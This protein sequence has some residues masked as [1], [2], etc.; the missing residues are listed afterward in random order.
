MKFDNLFY[1]YQSQ[2]MTTLAAQGMVATSQ[3]LA[4]QAGLS[5]LHKGGN[6]IDA[7]IAC[8]AA[9]TVLEPT[10]NGIGGDAFALI[11]K[12]GKLHGLNASGYAPHNIS[13]NKIKNEGYNHLPKYGW[14]P[15]TIPGAPA[16][17]VELNK[18]YGNLNLQEI[19]KPAIDYA[20]KGFPISPILGKYWLAAFR[21]YKKV[22]K[23]EK[24]KH[25]FDIFAPEGRPPRISE[26]WNSPSHAKTL[27]LIAETEGK[28]FYR[29]KIADKIVSFSKKTGGYITHNDLF[30]Y[31][32]DWVKPI[33]VNYH[34]YDIWELPPNGQGLVALIALNILDQYKFN[35][36][37]SIDTYHKQIEALKLAFA[38]GK[39]YI[40]DPA[41]MSVK[42]NDLLSKEYAKKRRELIS[43]NAILPKAGRP[44]PGETV[45]L[46]TADNKGNMVSYIQ[47][48]YMGFGS[49]L[50]IPDTGISLQNRGHSFSLN[51]NEENCLEGGKKPYH[52]II[53]G[54]ITKN[55]KAIGPFGVMGG[56]MQPQG[57]LQVVM[58]LIDFKLNPQAALDAPR[59]QWIKNKQIKVEQHFPNYK[60]K[61]LKRK[62]HKIEVALESG[63]FGRGQ[64]IIRNSNGILTGGTEP[65]TDGAIAV[66]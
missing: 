16:A 36:N 58:N 6:A 63:S 8:A 59:W 45:Y 33:S 39:K 24:F 15:V 14:L 46:A 18:K 37:D 43:D 4:A 48:N 5:I 61:A 47:S 11:W 42:V 30:S 20:E 19:L 27:Q 3:P 38:D 7:A 55:S 40:T 52:T 41:R 10:S 57:H 65:R 44:Q 22:L 50:V 26:L 54:F 23:E 60:A 2:R 51:K 53:P 1:P 9:L 64:I 17:W 29:G 66:W 12:D 34:D 13:I 25:W 32:P 56:F 62:G 21:K 28:S 31:K 49:G 35:N